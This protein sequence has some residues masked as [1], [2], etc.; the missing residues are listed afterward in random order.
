MTQRDG[1]AVA[2]VVP[3]IMQARRPGARPGFIEAVGVNGS[4]GGPDTDDRAS[5]PLCTPLQD[6]GGVARGW[7]ALQEDGRT[8]NFET[9]KHARGEV[10]GGT[11]WEGLGIPSPLN[12]EGVAVLWDWKHRVRI[13]KRHSHAFM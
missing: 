10:A 6:S 9:W 11:V 12:A 5:Q 1:R 4:L 8:P 7:L 13:R 2:R 3:A